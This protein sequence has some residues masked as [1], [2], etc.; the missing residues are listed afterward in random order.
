[1]NQSLFSNDEIN[2][3]ILP[4]D[5]LTYY[6]NFYSNL[7]LSSFIQNYPDWRHDQIQIFGKKS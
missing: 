6:E 1:M 7:H 4:A 5:I 3:L 2:K